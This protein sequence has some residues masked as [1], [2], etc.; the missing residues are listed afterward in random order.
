MSVAIASIITD[1]M[2]IIMFIISIIA[3]TIVIVVVI[4]S[5]LFISSQEFHVE[6]MGEDRGG[7]FSLKNFT[8]LL[9]T[10]SLLVV[11]LLLLLLYLSPRDSVCPPGQSFRERFFSHM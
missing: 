1:M 7:M 9:Q 8:G 10:L 5:N 6:V 2:I 4:V 11:L 3:I